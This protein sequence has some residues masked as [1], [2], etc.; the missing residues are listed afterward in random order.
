VEIR[1][2]AQ[3][4]LENIKKFNP[5]IH[6]ITNYVAANFQ[7]NVLLAIGASPVMAHSEDEVEDMVAISDALVLNIGT[8]TK[9]IV[10]SMIIAGKRAKEL[11]KPVILDPVGAGATKFR[12]NAIEKILSEVNVDIIR[13]NASEIG[14]ICGMEGNTKGVDS[15]I[16]PEEVLKSAVDFSN[17]T[18]TV[19]VISGA[20]DYIVSGEEVIKCHNGVPLLGKITG[21]GCAVTSIIGA[22]SAVEENKA[23]ASLFGLGLFGIAGEIA[24]ANAKGPGSFYSLLIDSL[25]NITPDVFMKKLKF[26]IQRSQS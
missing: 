19:V 2:R 6:N 10:N 15:V 24:F 26:D 7:A 11:K 8:P 25:Y 4:A 9:S 16:E 12:N 18:G 5:L 1:E 3:K 20:T 22:F 14:A 13:G 23:F 17:K 21:S